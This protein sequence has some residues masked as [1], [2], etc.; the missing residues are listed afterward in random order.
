MN[1]SSTSLEK[2]KRFRQTRLTA[3][4]AVQ[5]HSETNVSTWLSDSEIPNVEDRPL[6][7]K[8]LLHKL[9]RPA[10]IAFSHH[11]HHTL[12]STSLSG[13]FRD[14]E[15]KS[16]ENLLV[17]PG[18][19]WKNATT[20]PLPSK[21][22]HRVVLRRPLVIQP[23]THH[24][25]MGQTR[26]LTVLSEEG[27]PGYTV[28]IHGSGPAELSRRQ[29]SVISGVECLADGSIMAVEDN[30]SSVFSFTPSGLSKGKQDLRTIF[31]GGFEQTESLC[32]VDRRY[33]PSGSAGSITCVTSQKRLYCLSSLDFQPLFDFTLT[34]YNGPVFTYT[35]LGVDLNGY[36]IVVS[37]ERMK[38]F[39]PRMNFK[40]IHNLAVKI[41]DAFDLCV[42]DK[43]TLCVTEPMYDRIVIFDLSSY[44]FSQS[45]ANK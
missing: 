28:D 17:F 1:S 8:P 42:N 27:K 25:V 4:D 26:Y 11:N 31:R 20:T 12:I 39:D 7:F 9:S 14:P 30:L 38:I 10:G 6:G 36:L 13:T 3:L 40:I 29:H 35:C 21:E 24:I 2:T 18:S 5:I 16:K 37:K 44:S 23:H 43:N 22:D 15:S 19:E 34:T 45:L 41:K 33:S 32:V